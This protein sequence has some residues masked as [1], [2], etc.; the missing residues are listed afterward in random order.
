MCIFVYVGGGNVPALKKGRSKMDF[1]KLFSLN[2]TVNTWAGFVLEHATTTNEYSCL[3]KHYPNNRDFLLRL[4]KKEFYYLKKNIEGI[5][6][7]FKELE[8]FF[9]ENNIEG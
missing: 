9:S 7:K 6:E 4:Y 3:M 2:N 8:Q 1:E 5:N